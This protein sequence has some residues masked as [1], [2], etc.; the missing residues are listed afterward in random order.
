[1][2][3]VNSA[4]DYGISN[5]L[6]YLFGVTE[7]LSTA[8]GYCCGVVCSYILNGRFTFKS[9]GNILRFIVVNA[10]SLSA[11]ILL[12]QLWSSVGLEYWLAKAITIAVTTVINFIG[13]RLFVF[14][15][16]SKN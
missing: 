7:W 12:A 8:L 14:S 1:V 3:A 15:A 6:V 16:E 10:V 5:A 2:G 9:K 11:S 13:Y 4:L